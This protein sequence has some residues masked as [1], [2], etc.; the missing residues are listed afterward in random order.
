[1]AVLRRWAIRL[2]QVGVSRSARRGGEGPAGV[3][4]ADIR[5]WSES[6]RWSQKK[7]TDMA[8]GDEL[9]FGPLGVAGPRM[10]GT[11]HWTCFEANIRMGKD[12]F[13]GFGKTGGNCFRMTDGCFVGWSVLLLASG[14]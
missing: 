1:M 10:S 8:A 5:R 4:G 12:W 9:Q 14:R 6:V 13:R 3:S 2:G 7:A 11:G